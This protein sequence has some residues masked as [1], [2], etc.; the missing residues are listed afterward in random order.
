MSVIIFLIV[1]AVLILVHEYGHFIVAKKSGVRVDEFGLGFPPRVFAWKPKE[2]ETE[3]SLNILPLGGFVRIF[4]ED[5]TQEGVEDGVDA[6]RSM[7]AK[8]PLTQISI[9][10]AGVVCNI[11]IAWFFLWISMIVGVPT[12]VDDTMRDDAEVV[13]TNVLP[14][15]PASELLKVGDV[16]H[17][18]NG[19]PTVHVA[20]V[21]D[22]ISSSQGE[23]MTLTIERRGVEEDLVIVAEQGIVDEERY[24]LGVALGAVAVEEHNPV[25]AIGTSFVRT[26]EMTGAV[27]L[28]L[29]SFF[30]DLF[31]G[32]ANFEQITGPV[33][34]A[35]LVG[36]ASRLGIVS[37]LTFT[38][39]ISVNLALINLVPFPALDGGRIL[40]ILIEV[41]TRQKIP[42]HIAQYMN[43]AGFLLLL[44]LM[45]VVTFHDILRIFA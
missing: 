42:A 6:D 33:G 2:G 12:L 4:G 32:N 43:T 31:V 19:I 34:L 41:V 16:I 1:L 22:T 8:G 20:D 28:G 17:A 40:F 29:A 44:L 25:T 18:V 38:A 37:L 13:V 5:P 14:D 35:G 45:A 36:D 23:E 21:Q 30:G 3:Y 24:A 26:Y 7:T 10:A 9:L 15:A 27:A 11:L 39:V